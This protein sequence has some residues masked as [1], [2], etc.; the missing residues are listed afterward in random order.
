MRRQKYFKSAFFAA[1]LV[2]A[3][4]FSPAMGQEQSLQPMGSWAL[5]KVD[6]SAQGGN[7]YCTLSRKY[8]GNIVVSLGRNQTEEYSLAIDFQKDVFPKDEALK[9]NLQPGPGQIR[10][11]DMMPTSQKAV[12][13]RLGWDTGFFDAL[14]QSQQMKVK[15]ADKGY[16]FAMPEINKGQTDLNECMDGLKTA[17]KGGAK[18]AAPTTDV[19]AAQAGSGSSKFSAAK[20]PDSMA[21]VANVAAQKDSIAEQEKKILKNFADNM[22]AQEE[23][24]SKKADSKNFAGKAKKEEPIKQAALEPKSLE[25]KK[26][27]FAAPEKAVAASEKP[28]ELVQRPAENGALLA[29]IAAQK[30]LQAQRDKLQQKLQSAEAERQKV[31][32]KADENVAQMESSIKGYEQRVASLAAENDKLKSQSVAASATEA[33]KQEALKQIV[34]VQAEKTALEAKVK[35][36]EEQARKAM[37]AKN[38][39]DAADAADAAEMAKMT[40]QMQ[41]IEQ[42]VSALT[43]ENAALKQTSAG[44]SDAQQKL[45]SVQAEKAS[46]EQ[47]VKQMEAAAQKNALAASSA[48]ATATTLSSDAKAKAEQL[49]ALEKQSGDYQKQLIDFQK[50]IATLTA[51][52]ATLKTATA[53]KAKQGTTSAAQVTDLQQKLAALSTENSTLKQALDAKASGNMTPMPGAS[54]QIEELQ[55]QNKALQDKLAAAEK[56]VASSAGDDKVA[57]LVQAKT[58]ELEAANK[59]LEEKLAAAEKAAVAPA[60]GQDKAATQAIAAAEAKA[61]ELDIRNKQLE[62]TLRQAQTRIAET[63]L[64]TE[65]KALRKIADLESRLDAAQK[66][67]ASLAKQLDDKRLGQ[68]DSRL[69]LVAGDWNLES[70]TKRYNEAEREI[71]R[72]GQQLEVE[73]TSCNREKSEIENMLFDPA[74]T[75]QKQIEKLNDLQEKL[76]QAEAAMKDQQKL[77]QYT[78]DQ[79]LAQKTQ[80]LEAEK[81]SLQQQVASLKDAGGAAAVEPAAGGSSNAAMSKQIADMQKALADAKMESQKLRA[82]N[83]ALVNQSEQ[84]RAQLAEVQNN[85]GARADHVAAANIEM[86][87]LKRQLELKDKE[88]L[89][90]QNQLASAQKEIRAAKQQEAAERDFIAAKMNSTQPAAGNAAK[91][92]ETVKVAAVAPA[93]AAAGFGRENVQGLLQKAGITAGV[94]AAGAGSFGWSQNGIKGT[95]SV[96]AMNGGFDAMVQ[97]YIAQQKGQCNG[98]FASMP[99]PAAG[100]AKK[101]ALYEVACVGAQSSSSS[102][103]FFE[104]NGSFVAMSSQTTPENMDNAMDVRD[105]I[106]SNL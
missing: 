70:A 50:E 43:A 14:N 29:A 76:H 98:D 100:G 64:N 83:S 105:R 1:L 46:L 2:S 19:L 73:R 41:Q 25:S 42:R 78:V 21:A 68:E 63:A 57:A 30:D 7:S 80:A 106:A 104:D 13:I 16:S 49:A 88:S 38:A 54:K 101:N 72:L 67:N 28:V 18:E 24:V 61:Q 59:Q 85:G 39:A 99:S 82:E 66:D 87:K 37:E 53:D 94:Q 96:S 8:D 5:T 103:V 6:R 56:A 77:V 26:T 48:A 40:A 71:R 62:D 11:Y 84:A 3:S 20:A 12:V 69:K 15:I 97:Q 17:A 79:Q 92:A 95:A 91:V 9:I 35:Q 81:A 60:A 89:T 47:K 22:M 55:A 102:L 44:V 27:D 90:Y 74:V 51:E 75:E 45:A 31:A 58:Q 4:M 32:S 10:A 23:G 86:E 65:S 93:R 33:Q 36:A 52:N 34:M